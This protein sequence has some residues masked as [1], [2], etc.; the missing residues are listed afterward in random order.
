MSYDVLADLVAWL[1]ARLGVPCSAS[2]PA[3]APDEF[4]TLE[5][6]GGGSGIG[7]D[8]PN[9]AVQCW[10]STQ[11]G[12]YTLALAAREALLQCWESLPQ[13]CSVTVGGIYGFPDPDSRRPRYQLDVY[14][15]TRQ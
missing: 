5:R 2:V 12:A 9:L 1:P 4:V 10:S 7:V 6:T 3:S 13:V 14:M 15:V 8:R 11:A